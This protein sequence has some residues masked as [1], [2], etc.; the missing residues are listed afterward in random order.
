MVAGA[1]RTS[2]ERGSP[3]LEIIQELKRTLGEPIVDKRANGAFQGT[4]LSGLL[5]ARGIRHLA[6]CSNTIYVCVHTTLRDAHNWVY[7]RLLMA[8]C[9]GC[10]DPALHAMAV[11]IVAVKDGIFG[12]ITSTEAVFAAFA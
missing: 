2:L 4:K 1:N 7:E 3:G 11:K 9:C 12:C 10:I 5:M 8:D 6:F